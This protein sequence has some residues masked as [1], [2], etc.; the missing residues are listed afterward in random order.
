MCGVFFSGNMDK[1]RLPAILPVFAKKSQKK[2]R[3]SEILFHPCLMTSDEITNEFNKE[4]I[5]DFHL[6]PNRMIEY[7]AALSIDFTRF[8]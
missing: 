6:S 2:Q 7:D 3:V 4:G 1:D 8:N 5:N